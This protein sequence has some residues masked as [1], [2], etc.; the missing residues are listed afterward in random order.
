MSGG[1]CPWCA[2]PPLLGSEDRF[3]NCNGHVQI[4]LAFVLSSIDRRLPIMNDTTTTQPYIFI[5]RYL[6]FRI[7]AVANAAALSKIH[8]IAIK[9]ALIYANIV[10]YD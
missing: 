8:M 9:N 2:Q 10:I 5:S 3:S 4:D 1:A 7:L 6:T